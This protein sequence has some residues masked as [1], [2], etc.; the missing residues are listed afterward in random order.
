MGLW[1]LQIALI[2]ACIHLFLHFVRTTRGN[3]LIRGLFLTV[4]LGVAGLWGLSTALELEELQHILR[5]SLGYILILLAMIFQPELRRGIAQLGERTFA[6]RRRHQSNDALR[7][8]VQAAQSMA[9]RRDGALICFE[10]ESSLRTVIETGSGIG[11][12]VNARLIES[13]FHPGAPLHDGAVVVSQNQVVAAGCYLPLSKENALDLSLGTR[14]RAALGLTEETDAVVLVVSE[15]TGFISIASGGY[16]QEHVQSDKIEEQLRMNLK[17]HAGDKQSGRQGFLKFMLLSLRKD[18]VWL[19][20]SILLATGSFLAAHSSIEQVEPFI[21]TIIDATTTEQVTPGEREILIVAP[22]ENMRIRSDAGDAIQRIMVSGT[23]KQLVALGS[24]LSGRW[25]VDDLEWD[26][27]LLELDNIRWENKPFGLTF[28][29]ENNRAPNLIVEH[30]VQKRVAL[31]LDDIP[32][33]IEGIDEHYELRRDQANFD[34]TPSIELRGP[35]PVME[36]LLSKS[37]GSLQMRLAEIVLTAADLGPNVRTL[38]LHPDLIAKG[39]SIEENQSVR[40]TLPVLPVQ[41]ELAQPVRKDIAL[42]CMEPARASLLEEW[43]LPAN[44]QTAR[45]TIL[46]WG[47]LPLKADPDSAAYVERTAAIAKFVEENLFVFVDVAQ[48]PPRLEGRQVPVR[49]SWRKNWKESPELFGLSS[50][51]IT[52]YEKLEVRLESA[53]EILLDPRTKTED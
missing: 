4:I 43:S 20:G 15:E 17:S 8:I 48:L 5:G 45:Y 51:T 42:L 41:R 52:S 14:H 50:D 27:G 21:V 7:R 44:A 24:S 2:A 16:L 30:W 28:E 40:V 25:E 13:I 46:T 39:L 47:L 1:I 11:A 23:T 18:L 10:R 33:N 29:W 36:D 9:T 6:P 31:T 38:S 26:G 49:I 3:P 35:Q 19:L 34:P 32:I 53:K 22:L 37:E 12:R